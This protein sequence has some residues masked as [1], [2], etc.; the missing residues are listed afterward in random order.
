[1]RRSG[2]G[3]QNRYVTLTFCRDLSAADWIVHGDLP[4]Q[5]LVCSGPASFDAYAS[6]RFLPDPER[7]GQSEN[8]VDAGWRTDPLPTLF[9]VLAAPDDCYFCVREGIGHADAAIPD[10]AGHID[11]EK[12]TR[13][14][15]AARR[16]AGMGA[17]PRC[18]VLDAAAAASR[19]TPSRV[20]AV[21]WTPGRRRHVGHRCGMAGPVLAGRGRTSV[22]LARRSRMVPRPGRR[23]TRGR[24]R[25]DPGAYHPTHDR[26]AARRGPARP[27]R[28]PAVLPLN[29]QVPRV[30]KCRPAPGGSAAVRSNARIC[31][32][33]VAA[34]ARLCRGQ[35][36]DRTSLLRYATFT[37]SGWGS[38]IAVRG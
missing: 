26:S 10:D 1:M 14:A 6:L 19:A 8:D 33:R 37:T 2:A 27:H 16:A 23:S 21:S 32:S 29:S 36:A 4:W 22:H 5:Q 25:R 13:P 7:P 9:E 3:R 17:P 35:P 12:R 30:E 18:L 28:G 20:L 11:D 24:D 31:G 38:R 34:L 15:R